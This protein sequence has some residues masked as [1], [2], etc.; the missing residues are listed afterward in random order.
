MRYPNFPTNFATTFV[1]ALLLLLS[2]PLVASQNVLQLNSE[3]TEVT[4]LLEA[5]GHNIEGT[6]YLSH[7]EITFDS[8]SGRASGEIAIDARRSV[9]GNKS[10]D[11]TMRKKVLESEDHPLIVFVPKELRGTIVDSGQSEVELL[12]TLTLVGHE[13]PFTMP[14]TVEMSE[15][16]QLK[17]STTFKVPF[18]EWGLEDPS[19][20]FL[21][22]AKEVEVTITATGSLETSVD[23][24][25]ASD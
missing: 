9:S 10:R 20:L 18:I 2:S 8:E 21:R 11:K 7:G 19:I 4:F 13:H 15:G 24:S 23:A 12:G 14:A 25:A 22:V 16:G 5:T 3:D 17:V 1:A 6:L